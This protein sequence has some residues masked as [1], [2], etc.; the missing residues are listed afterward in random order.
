MDRKL[1]LYR[2]FENTPGRGILATA[3]DQGN[4][5]LALYARPHVVDNQTIALIMCERLSHHNL[6]SNLNAAYMYIEDGVG[7]QGHRFYLVK[8]REETNSELIAAWSRRT[9]N[10]ASPGDDSHKYLVFFRV[11]RIRPLVGN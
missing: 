8:E 7:Y 3:D 4:V 9:G 10:I 5:D 6:K 2:Y 1:D 11:T